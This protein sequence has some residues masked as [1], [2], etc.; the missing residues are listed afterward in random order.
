M[1]RSQFKF[2]TS[3]ILVG[4]IN[5]EPCCMHSSF[6]VMLKYLFFSVYA[7]ANMYKYIRLPQT[8]HTCEKSFRPGLQTRR[9]EA[10]FHPIRKAGWQ[11]CEDHF[12][13]NILTHHSTHTHTHSP[14]R[15]YYVAKVWSASQ[16]LCRKHYFAL[17]ICP[18]LHFGSRC[19]SLSVLVSHSLYLFP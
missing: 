17:L 10:H 4:K 18:I 12:H 6:V 19:A 14:D 5:S 15:P 3:I 13:M 11:M 16:Y 7:Y 8:S 9:E 2:C 1:Q